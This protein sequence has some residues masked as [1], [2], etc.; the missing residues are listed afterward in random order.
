M[1]WHGNNRQDKRGFALWMVAVIVVGIIVVSN[2]GMFE[3][4]GEAALFDNF[5]RCHPTV[6]IYHD[7]FA[8]TRAIQGCI[9]AMVEFNVKMWDLSA[10]RVLVEEAGGKYVT[11][12]E[13][14]KDGAPT[15][16]SMVFGKPSVVDLVLPYFS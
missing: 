15:S 1:W 5:I 7:V 8:S 2:R 14:K 11:I 9:G 3:R 4:S 12:R 16:Y 10:T 6:Y 13:I